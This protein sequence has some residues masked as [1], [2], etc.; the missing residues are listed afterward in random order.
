MFSNAPIDRIHLLVNIL[1]DAMQNSRQW[2]IERE[3]GEPTTECLTTMFPEDPDQDISIT[4]W[5]GR[6]EGLNMNE[7]IMLQRTWSA[8]PSAWH[9]HSSLRPHNLSEQISSG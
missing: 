7:L 6:K 9:S 2:K 8:W 3:R 1:L 4:L 5:V